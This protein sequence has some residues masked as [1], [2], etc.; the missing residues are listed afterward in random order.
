MAISSRLASEVVKN[1][2]GVRAKIS[3]L[4]AK[5]SLPR[6]PVLVAV[7]KTKPPALLQVAYDADQRHFGENYVQEILG[8]FDELPKD[9]KWHFIGHLQTNKVKALLRVPNLYMVETVD[10][11][12]LAKALDKAC[13][14]LSRDDKLRVMV[15]VNTS[16]EASKSGCE[17]SDCV[18]VV[19]Y[20][21][22][23]CKHLAFGGLMTIGRLDDTPQT[24]CFESLVSCRKVVSEAL[25]IPI[26]DI[27]LSM[28]MS[29]DYELAIEMGSTNVRVGS[30]IFGHRDYGK[31]EEEEHKVP[32]NANASASKPSE[33]TVSSSS[34]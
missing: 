28:G 17:P 32:A 11:A 30:T 33:S 6:E 14:S 2:N 27:A 25:S 9:I 16:G 24:D 23:E 4:T 8:K 34:I 15:Q 12:K 19:K 22:E 10:S 21:V 26:N 18:G 20:I 5:L 7:S 13:A 1:L 29:G 31:E 3:A